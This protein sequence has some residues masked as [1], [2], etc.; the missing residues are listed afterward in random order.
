[1]VGAH[2]LAPTC[3]RSQHVQPPA[4]A[5]VAPALYTVRCPPPPSTH[6]LPPPSSPQHTHLE[7]ALQRHA[8][9]ALVLVGAAREEQLQHLR[10]GADVHPLRVRHRGG[11]PGA[12]ALHR[13]GLLRLGA[14]L[15]PRQV[16]PT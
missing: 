3:T 6:A 2:W 10:A 13:L 15:R 9:L 12:E 16:L 7:H 11:R 8:I 5:V 4:R 1:M 14:L